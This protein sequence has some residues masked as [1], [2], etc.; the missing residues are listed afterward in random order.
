[1]FLDLVR[2]P[3]PSG[4]EAAVAKYIQEYLKRIGI[5]SYADNAGRRGGSNTGNVIAKIGSGKPK[6]LFVAHMDTVEEGGR[7][8]N[9]I[10]KNGIISSDGS[11]ILGADDKAAVAALM[12]AMKAL[13]TQKIPTTYCVFS[14][15]EE[16][17]MNG[18]NYLDVDKD[19]DF[20]F[21]IDGQSSVG[22][23]INRALG[24]LSFEIS[25]YG[26]EAHAARNPEMGR[27]AIKTAGLILSS[28]N[29]GRDKRYNVLNIGT[30]SG[31]TRDNVVPGT[32]ILTGEARATSLEGIDKIIKLVEAATK[33]ACTI[34][35]CKYRLVKRGLIPPFNVSADAPIIKL[36]RKASENAGMKFS[37]EMLTATIQASILSSRG[38]A[39][40]GLQRGGR[41]P[42]ARN[43]SIRIDELEKTKR[44]IMEI[45]YAAKGQS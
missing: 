44:L 9:P 2:I 14:I 1:M 42:H 19:I 6:L 27:N 35:K 17:T 26:K 8:I 12:E 10:I 31:G 30:I 7:A 25:I 41:Y 34:T 20:I 3:S 11:T 33:K 39:A 16:T 5:P 24:C 13:K 45:G 22:G 23:F 40:L 15:Q 37:L 36:A 18:V 43:E 28:L 32:C 21:D 4:N 38:Y 29:F